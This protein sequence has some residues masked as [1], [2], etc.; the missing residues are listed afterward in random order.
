MWVKWQHFEEDLST[1]DQWIQKWL[2]SHQEWIGKSLKS[3]D[4]TILS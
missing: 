2:K 4:I 1:I 3:T